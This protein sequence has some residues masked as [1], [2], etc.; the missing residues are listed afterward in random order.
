[1]RRLAPQAIAVLFLILPQ[2]GIAQHFGKNSVQ[3][4]N[5][6]WHYLQS[7]HFDIYY[8]PG[9]ETIAE[10]VADVAE[11]SYVSLS[12]RWNYR[13]RD[14]I[15]FIVYKSHND[16]G[17]S[18][19]NLGP[20][21]ESVGGFTEF[22]KNRVA[23]P[24]EG[25]YEQLRH[26]THHELTHAVMLQMMFGQKA[27]AIITGISGSH[28]PLWFIEGLAEYE[29]RGWD[30]ESDMFIRDAVIS[31]YLPPISQLYAFLSYK[32]GQSVF[33]FI[34][35][36]YGEQKVGELL[37]HVKSSK[38]V[39]RALQKSLGIG[40]Q[41]LSAQWHKYLKQRYWPVFARLEEPSDFAKQV[42]FHT[43]ER[44][45]I[46]NS[47]ALSPQGDKIAY[48]SDKSGFFDI[49]VT[50]LVDEKKTVKLVS[51]Q[52]SGKLEEL[53]WL[54]PG[55]TW[56]PAGD[57]IAFAAKSRE[58]DALHIVDVKK[59]KIIQSEKFALDGLYSP[60]WSPA[61][62]EIAFVGTRDGRS[63][64]YVYR[65]DSKTIQ[66]VSDDIFS[67]LAP[68]WSPT[69]DKI[70]FVS[71]RAEY[72]DA[73][74]LPRTFEI[75]NHSY[76]QLDVYFV[77]VRS[78]RISR[79]TKTPANE[80]SP[81]WSPDGRKIAF[82]SDRNGIAN[83]FVKDM[84]D[85]DQTDRLV[86][87]QVSSGNGSNG[88]TDKAVGREAYPITNVLTG[89]DH[90]SWKNQKLAFTSFYMG[91]FDVFVMRNPLRIKTNDLSLAE[92]EFLKRGRE[93]LGDRTDTG[94]RSDGLNGHDEYRHFVFGERF[95]KGEPISSHQPDPDLFLSEDKYKSGDGNYRV[96]KYRTKFSPDIITGA[97]GHDPFFGFQGAAMF[98]FSDLMGRHRINL[99][100][101]VFVDFQN[102]DFAANYFYLPRQTDYSFGLFKNSYLFFSQG[103]FIAQ[104][105][106]LGIHVSLSR[107]FDRY[108]RIELGATFRYISRE[109]LVD[110]GTIDTEFEETSTS[111]MVSNFGYIKDTVLWG[112][113]GPK[114]GSRFNVSVQTSTHVG[115]G[116][117]DFRIYQFDYRSYFNFQKNYTLAFRFAAGLSEGRHRQKFFLGGVPNWINLDFRNDVGLDLNNLYFSNLVAPLRGFDY[118]EQVGS[119]FFLTNL[120]LRIPFI[121]YFDMTWPLPLRFSNIRG[122]LFAD[123]GSAWDGDFSFA[124]KTPDRGLILDDVR[125]SFGWGMQVHIGFFL[126]RYDVAWRTDLDTVS[127]ARHL[128]SIGSD[129]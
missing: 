14:R 90:L 20:S 53:H 41:E 51:G 17:Q 55:I 2:I 47:G 96:K 28:V 6:E 15:V 26:V 123:V 122:S 99:L 106:S 121:N 97:A 59:R 24:Y 5:F 65:L 66:K 33:N 108:R 79:V 10:F 75:Q 43:R 118:Y 44:N 12:D 88:H 62:E 4:T 22:F 7:R 36:R 87:P 57:R 46:N 127:R 82:V 101:D 117:L 113:T 50:S 54:R 84:T 40:V 25:S 89:I 128:F 11:S 37:T 13:L 104:D 23:I 93:S 125:M 86:A 105:N 60:D 109:A 71:D 95:K 91:G 124:K 48:L 98:S 32:G 69:G 112:M 110:L 9:G 119:K 115:P 111:I 61:G 21:E 73:R 45:F 94:R 3:Y 38:S 19:L 92:V 100:T 77:D 68:S 67:D 116:R 39:D 16:F 107:P 85:S 72:V 81:V 74:D 120:E 29:S 1:M 83:I 102:S 58:Q 80:K 78:G 56:S 34:A 30:S 114:A 64:I 52:R 70:V 31:G 42:T 76:R 103:Q 27:F 8:Y 63:D 126:L 129:F 35:E 49:Y 18:N